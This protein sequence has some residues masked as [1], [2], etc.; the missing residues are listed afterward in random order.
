MVYLGSK[1]KLAKEIIPIIEKYIHDNHITTYIEPFV[2]GANIIDKVSCKRKL[3]Y[4]IHKPLIELHK[5][6]QTDIDAIPDSF[7]SEDYHE[8]RKNKDKY[9]PWMVGAVGFLASF[10]GKYFAGDATHSRKKEG[11][12]SRCEELISN[13]KKQASK[14]GYREII[15]QCA[16]YKSIKTPSEKCL[17]YCDPPYHNTT[18]YKY[19]GK[20]VF[21]YDEFLLW[22]VE[23]AKK[24]IVLVSEYNINHQDFE[25]IW[26][27]THKTHI[28]NGTY[29]RGW[30]DRTEKLYVVKTK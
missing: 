4:D 16:D 7:T 5:K 13:L 24:H 9:E 1:N 2:G 27:K 11:R 18:K 30:E 20:D 29:D 28:G 21:D 12:R 17:I 14:D 26:E 22:C 19:E 25:K 3:G 15:F 8:V 23:Q 10:S 6:A